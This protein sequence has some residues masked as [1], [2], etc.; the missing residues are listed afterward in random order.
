MAVT[1]NGTRLYVGNHTAGTVSV[2]DVVARRVTATVQ[3]GGH[4]AAIAITNNGDGNDTDETVY[5]AQF[6]AVLRPGADGSEGRD[7]GK[8]GILRAFTVADPAAVSTVTLS[9]LANSGF[10][11]DRTNFC[12][13]SRTGGAPASTLFC[14]DLNAAAGSAAITQ[15]PQGVYPNQ[16]QSIV[17]RGGRL[18]LPNIGAQPEPPVR[19]D[20]NVQG[21]VHVV[22]AATRAEVATLHV[23]LNQQI[24]TEIQALTGTGGAGLVGLN[25]LFVNDIVAIDVNT[26]GTDAL[27]VSRGANYVLRAS[28]DTNGAISIGAPNNVRR[29]QT[30]NMPNGVAISRDGR[31]AYTNNEVNVSVTAIALDTNTVLTRDIASGEPPRPDTFNHAVLVGK[32]AFFTA[33]GLPDNQLFGTDIRNFVPLDFKGKASN[34]GWSSCGSCHP[35]G[36]ADGVTWIFPA[37]P[38]QTL[39]LDGFFA[40]DNPADQKLVLWSAGRGSNTDFNNNSRGVQGGCGFASDGFRGTAACNATAPANPDIYD[41][42]ITQG[43]SDALD[44]QTLWV[45]TVRPPILPQPTDT[46]ALARGRAVFQTNCASCHGGAKWTKSQVLHADNPAFDAAPG[47]T[48]PG[49]PRDPGLSFSGE[50]LLA[51]TIN[52]ATLRY[53]DGVGTF[54]ANDPLEIR[55]PGAGAASGARAL[56]VVGFNSPSLVGL[57]YHTPYLHNGAA[58]TLEA[59]FTLHTLPGAP[60]NANTIQAVL[61]AT[62]RQDLLVLLN[63]IDGRTDTFVSAADT[64]RNNVAPGQGAQVRHANLTGAQEVPPVTTTTASGTAT[65]TVNAA[66]SQIDFVLEVTTPVENIREVHLHIA[67]IGS[68]GPIVLDFCTTALVTPPANVPVP[69]TCPAAPFRITGSLTATNLRAISAAITNAGIANFND[70][71]AHVLSG[72]AYVNLHT[73]AF[74]GGEIRGQVVTP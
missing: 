45:Q 60:A 1:P 63:A 40:K 51:Y 21:L 54:N 17:L 59:V 29:F 13:Q 67:P 48:P 73:T 47:A 43:A 32:L 41:H 34:N 62:D 22:N 18:F 56:G 55:G 2:I 66:R 44:A 19:F 27:I 14:P 11:A 10:T 33:L 30:G 3:V 64:F 65:L 68:N 25:G 71:V 7:T 6:Y 24:R 4:P 52:G 15:V 50:Q 36:L 23:N 20:T 9:P 46:A 74:P 53:L 58:Q 72:D 35:D 37:G 69:P 28:I 8:Q 16:F 61:S 38:R 70:V 49:I 31:R 5:V 42:G 26:A 12:P 57:R 39:P